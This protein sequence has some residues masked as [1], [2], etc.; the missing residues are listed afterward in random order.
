M[1]L[2]FTLVATRAVDQLNPLVEAVSKTVVARPAADS[3]LGSVDSLNKNHA[4]ASK[5][6]LDFVSML[7]ALGAPGELV[8]CAAMNIRIL[9]QC[10]VGGLELIEAQVEVVP[11]TAQ[12]SHRFLSM[13][14]RKAFSRDAGCFELAGA[15]MSHLDVKTCYFFYSQLLVAVRNVLLRLFGLHKILCTVD[16]MLVKLSLK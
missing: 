6:L 3:H 16:L 12:E 4:C 14:N 9:V 10:Q 15:K 8:K 2:S 13:R 11:M 5:V 7:A 1:S